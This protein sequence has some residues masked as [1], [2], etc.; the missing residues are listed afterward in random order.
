MISTTDLAKLEQLVSR[1]PFHLDNVQA[2][3]AVFA[4]WIKYGRVEDQN[5]VDLWTYCFI[6]RNL[7]V[8]FYRNTNLNPSDFDLLVA[9]VFERIMERRYTVRDKTRYTNWVAVICR[10]SFVNYLRGRKKNLPFDEQLASEVHEEPAVFGDDL[11]LL[12]ELLEGAIARLPLYLQGVIRMR[13]IEQLSYVVISE[14]L[15]KKIEV[16]RSYANKGM[17]KLRGDKVLCEILK[18]EFREDLKN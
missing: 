14:R 17:K 6:W 1:L 8:K 15:N 16:V 5:I 10:N 18:K 12:H 11:A 4:R 13:L 3:N 9:R 2:A 7:L